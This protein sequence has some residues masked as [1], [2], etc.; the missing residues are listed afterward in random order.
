MYTEARLLSS[1]LLSNCGVLWA[2][3]TAEIEAFNLHLVTTTYREVVSLAGR[4]ECW[5]VVLTMMSFIWRELWKVR[6]ESDTVNGSAYNVVMVGQYLW[7][8][9]Q[10]HRIMDDFLRAQFQKHP[11]V[12]SHITLYLFEHRSPIV[13]VVALKQK[14]KVQA[15]TM[16]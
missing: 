4:A 13:E 8:T 14:V 9:L 3:M 10:S 11:E 6:V 12:A 2:Q 16:I 1:E 15:K 5:T 7:G